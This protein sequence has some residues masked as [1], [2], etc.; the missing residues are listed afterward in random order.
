MPA[1]STSI[2]ACLWDGF[3]LDSGIKITGGSGVLLVG[4]EAFKWRPWE[5]GKGAMKLVNEKGQFDVEDEVWG[6]FSLVWPK[7]DLLILGLG[8]EM[9]P[10][11]PRVRQ[12]LNSLG[13]RVDIQ[14]TRNAAA[15]Y[16]LLATERGLSAVAGA[17][18]PIGFREGVGVK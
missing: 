2:N 18:I 14:D 12:H 9:R 16:N 7:P 4:G 17:L 11:S 8:K 6:L 13:I 3:H 15:Q 1:P 5:A 10:I